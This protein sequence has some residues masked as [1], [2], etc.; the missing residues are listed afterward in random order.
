VS[1]PAIGILPPQ[2]DLYLAQNAPAN[3]NFTATQSSDPL[4]LTGVTATFSLLRPNSATP[5]Y[6]FDA[7]PEVV[8]QPNGQVGVIAVSLSAT[9]TNAL[10]QDSGWSYVL[11]M[12]DVA[13]P[14]VTVLSWGNV[15]VTPLMQG[16]EQ[17]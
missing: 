4:T 13:V 14:S 10:W 7:P 12:T 9:D 2:V 3:Y 5:A 16:I 11:A 8:I 6:V 17:S 15:F 1:V